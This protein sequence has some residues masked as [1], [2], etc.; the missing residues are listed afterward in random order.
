MIILMLGVLC[1]SKWFVSNAQWGSW[2]RNCLGCNILNTRL[3]G[4]VSD[5]RLKTW[6]NNEDVRR[7]RRTS[8]HW[9][10]SLCFLVLN[11]ISLSFSSDSLRL[12]L[13]AEIVSVRLYSSGKEGAKVNG[14]A[15]RLLSQCRTLGSNNSEM[16]RPPRILS[17]SAG[18]RPLHPCT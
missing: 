4:G 3:S 17:R 2:S 8:Y 12:S 10:D 13:N 14:V 7:Y 5:L 15:V 1:D 6:P 9:L 11:S 18:T 16:H